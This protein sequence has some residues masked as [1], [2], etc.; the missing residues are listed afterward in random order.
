MFEKRRVGQESQEFK[1]LLVL[2]IGKECT[3]RN[4]KVEYSQWGGLKGRKESR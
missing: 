2:Q 4:N 3:N 1:A